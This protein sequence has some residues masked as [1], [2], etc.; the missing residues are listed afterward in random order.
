ML[1]AHVCP[2]R[3]VSECRI[4]AVNSGKE[5]LE[6]KLLMS[7][8]SRAGNALAEPETLQSQQWSTIL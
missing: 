2:D 4:F 6:G 1:R 5:N 7:L 3:S 8:F